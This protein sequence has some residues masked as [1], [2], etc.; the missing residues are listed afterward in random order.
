MFKTFANCSRPVRDACEDFAMPCERLA[1]VWRLVCESIRKTVA[2]SSHLSEIE[3]LLVQMVKTVL[4]RDVLRCVF[5][6]KPKWQLVVYHALHL[7]T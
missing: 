6:M 2:N 4:L 3:A 5:G 7:G 1:T